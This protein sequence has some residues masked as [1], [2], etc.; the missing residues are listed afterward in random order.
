[1]KENTTNKKEKENN[2]SKFRFPQ[3]HSELK[4]MQQVL[5]Q[6]KTAQSVSSQRSPGPSQRMSGPSGASFT[7]QQ[8][9]RKAEEMASKV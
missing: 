3:S 7:Q 8:N 2:A 4:E 5:Q 9:S 6:S 1:M